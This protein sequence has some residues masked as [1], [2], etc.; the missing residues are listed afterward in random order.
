[1][2][3]EL[4]DINKENNRTLQEANSLRYLIEVFKNYFLIKKTVEGCKVDFTLKCNQGVYEK[5]KH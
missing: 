1:M 5:T 2:L 4:M 3:N